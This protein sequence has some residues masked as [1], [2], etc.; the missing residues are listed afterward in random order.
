MSRRAVT[1]EDVL[2]PRPPFDLTTTARD[3]LA[4]VAAPGELERTE[5]DKVMTVAAGSEPMYQPESQ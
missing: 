2:G 3:G 4:V 1:Q 5:L